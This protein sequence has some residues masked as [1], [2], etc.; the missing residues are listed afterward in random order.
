VVK[1][2][3]TQSTREQNDRTMVTTTV[4]LNKPVVL[5][6]V[7]LPSRGL[8]MSASPLV[9]EDD[10]EQS[11]WIAKKKRMRRKRT[12]TVEERSRCGQGESR[13][14]LSHWI[15]AGRDEDGSMTDDEEQERSESHVEESHR[16]VSL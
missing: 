1:K 3:E 10:E 4:V 2:A 7:L 5:V 13:M 15:G 12:S 14:N 11:F 8:V 9:L 16:I 6:R